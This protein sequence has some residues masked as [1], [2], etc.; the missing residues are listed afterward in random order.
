ML[1]TPDELDAA[2]DMISASPREHGTL[3]LIACR[4]TIDERAVLEVARL[5]PASGVAGDSWNLRACRHMPDGWPDPARQVTLM[6]ARVIAL[7]AGPRDR[8]A[9]AGDQLYVDLHLG[10]DNLPP[11]TRLEIGP[12]VLEVT[13]PPH[14][15]CAKFSERFGSEALRWVN[16]PEGRALN[17]RGIHARVVVAGE[18]RRGDAIRKV[19][20]DATDALAARAASVAAGA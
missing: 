13:E 16:A 12:A 8:W 3:E 2:L 15:G 19:V 18:I 6:N 17:L 5:D 14:R 1:R 7:L 4:P 9:I 11:G 10:L 20:T